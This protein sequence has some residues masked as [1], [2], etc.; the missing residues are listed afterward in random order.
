M[1]CVSDDLSVQSVIGS[2]QIW[3]KLIWSFLEAGERILFLQQHPLD[4][5]SVL[6]ADGAVQL[7]GLQQHTCTHTPLTRAR[8]RLGGTVSFPEPYQYPGA[9]LPRRLNELFLDHTSS[10]H[11]TAAQR[12]NNVRGQSSTRTRGQEM[13]H[14]QFLSHTHTPRQLTAT[15]ACSAVGLSNGSHIFVNYWWLQQ[16]RLADST[17]VELLEKV[18]Y[19]HPVALSNSSPSM[20]ISTSSSILMDKRKQR[21]RQEAK[22]TAS[23]FESQRLLVE[24]C[25]QGQIYPPSVLFL[26]LHFCCEHS[27]WALYFNLFFVNVF[28][29]FCFFYLIR[30]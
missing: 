2:L 29:L 16:I 4:H 19:S 22:E 3:V 15:V 6:G 10:V 14:T 25:T 12:E 27:I 24:G 11:L 21:K 30:L 18:L 7:P 13:R 26:I 9:A 23:S 8:S 17:C 5:L 1:F 28:C 20:S